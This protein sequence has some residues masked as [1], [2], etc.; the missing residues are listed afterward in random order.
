MHNGNTKPLF[1]FISKSRGQSNHIG[2]LENTLPEHIADFFS[3]VFND[4]THPIPDFTL[5]DPLSQCMPGI[6]ITE[7]GVT[8]LI[9]NLDIPKSSGPGVLIL[10]TGV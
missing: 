1:N 5:Q 7:A 6:M 2:C 4:S 10:F 8:T 3:T 9:K